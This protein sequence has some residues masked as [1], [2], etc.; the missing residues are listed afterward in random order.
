MRG[1]QIPSIVRLSALTMVIVLTTLSLLHAAD[2]IFPKLSGRVV[3]NANLLSTS[4]KQQLV[5]LLKTHEDKTSNQVVVVTLKSLQSRTI[6]EFGYQLGRHWGIG[7]EGKNNGV[8]LVVA[9]NERKVRIEVGYGLEGTLTDAIS[10]SIIESKILPEFRSGDMSGGIIVGVNTLLPILEGVEF[11][12]G[13]HS[14]VPKWKQILNS[15]MTF[16]V[17]LAVLFIP[18]IIL[19]VVNPIDAHRATRA[20]PWGAPRRDEPTDPYLRNDHTNNHYSPGR[21]G[22]SGFGGGFGGG[23]GGFGG[24]GASGGW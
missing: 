12:P 8:L 17:I 6:E 18:A 2:V 9:P 16:L 11:Q 22:G 23:G 4:T 7:Q 10:R 13:Q 3:D 15:P 5:A 21:L 14:T 20:Q 1:S 24:G 19:F